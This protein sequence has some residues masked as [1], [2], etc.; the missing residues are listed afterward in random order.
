MHPRTTLT[1]LFRSGV[2]A[3]KG[4]HAVK[5]WLKTSAMTAPTHV[6]AAG[7]AATA[8]YEGL[9]REWKSFLP[10][11]LV[12]KT[13]HLGST[14]LGTNVNAIEAGHPIPDTC[15]LEAGR[16]ALNFVQ[17]CGASSRLLCLIS[18]GASS[19][20]E[21][22]KPG[23]CHDDLIALN[24]TAIGEGID[25]AEI[26]RRRKRISMVKGGQLL[27]DFKG[28]SVHCV[29]I[30]DVWGDSIDVIGSGLGAAPDQPAFAYQAHIIGSNAVARAAVADATCANGL[31][32]VA[33]AETMFSD[34]RAVARKIAYQ[35]KNGPN[36]VYIFGGEPTVILPQ[37]PGKG[38]RN[39]AL[40]LEL[41]RHF[42]DRHDISGLAAGT[43]GSDGPTVAAGG[44][45]D[46]NT[47]DAAQGATDALSTAD[48]AR[49]LAR[50]GDQFITGPTGTNVMDLTIIIKGVESTSHE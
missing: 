24:E 34:V 8:M 3:V 46:G 10:T 42:R 15:S 23:L 21:H 36:G 28:D 1:Q 18:G 48:S 6:F 4:D 29:A 33:N 38:G 22:L 9:P 41:A 20:V 45:F 12:T 32:V 26:N 47:F 30:S 2:C 11:L 37:N 16:E 43:D 7:K 14:V 49:Y 17:N 44:F 13:D 39:Q 35:V 31:A 27:S 25:I 19:L 50:V 5:S 40:A